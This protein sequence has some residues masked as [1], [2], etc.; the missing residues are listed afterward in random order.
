MLLASI[1]VISALCHFMVIVAFRHAEAAVLSPLVYLELVT[2]TLLGLLFFMDSPPIVTLIGMCFVIGSG[3]LIWLADRD[4]PSQ[5]SSKRTSS[6]P[7]I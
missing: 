3:L 5:K 2:A 7:N 1:G 4:A 6:L